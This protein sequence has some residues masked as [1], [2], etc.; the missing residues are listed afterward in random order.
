MRR[1]AARIFLAAAFALAVAG[2][3]GATEPDEWFEQRHPLSAGGTVSVE[4]INGSVLIEGWDR[5]QV[6]IRA[7]KT[8]RGEP[9]A[10]DA[11]RIEVEA[12]PDRIRVTTRYPEDRGVEVIVAYSL[13]VPRRVRLDRVWTVNGDIQLRGV[14]GTGALRT[15]NGS[16]EVLDGAGSFSA[17]TM[18]GDVRL[19]LF[20]LFG[21]AGATAETVNGSVVLA[22]TEDADAELEVHNVNG[23]FR[24]EL[25]LLLL[26]GANGAALRGRLGRGG[27]SL[28][29]RTVNGGI[30][31]VVARPIV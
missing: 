8:A 25:P 24:S 29:L 9:A 10:L 31:V 4:N 19:E 2:A 21:D 20:R 14:A 1:H 28:K 3:A 6:E 7:R 30:R 13:R 26:S 22:L 16:V 17:R 15:V 27:M 23:E 5:E 12:A 11:V 18:N